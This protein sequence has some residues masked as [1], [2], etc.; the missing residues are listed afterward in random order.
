MLGG[1]VYSNT[2]TELIT[3]NNA[4]T[5]TGY[6]EEIIEEHDVAFEA[7]IAYDQLILM[8]Y[9]THPP[10]LSTFYKLILKKCN[11]QL[12]ALPSLGESLTFGR[13]LRN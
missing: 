8:H 1:G 2:H 5:F 4:F 13:I 7:Y 6:V 10:V 9:N 11:R 3:I 12:A